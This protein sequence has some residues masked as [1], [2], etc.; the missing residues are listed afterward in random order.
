MFVRPVAAPTPRT[1]QGEQIALACAVVFVGLALAQL[2]RF[3]RLVPVFEG[4]P[5]WNESFNF[6]IVSFVV[7]CEVAAV[8]FLARMALSPLA[9]VCSMVAGWLAAGLWLVIV[10]LLATADT[11]VANIGLLGTIVKLQAGWPVVFLVASFA[12][13][14]VW[15]SYALWPL[16]YAPGKARKN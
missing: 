16:G 10:V 5:L 4:L 11:P 15:A 7:I 9:R 6:V 12:V 14:V 13:L 2:F 1:K 8:P 3:D